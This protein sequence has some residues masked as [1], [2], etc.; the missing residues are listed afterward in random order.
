MDAGAADISSLVLPPEDGEVARALTDLDTKLAAWESA[1]VDAQKELAAHTA[2]I[3]GTRS[4]AERQADT[5]ATAA[6]EQA[7]AS[8]EVE[9]LNPAEPDGGLGD[10]DEAL[11]G[12]LQPE[13][14]Q[15]VRLRYRLFKGRKTVQELV[16]DE[17]EAL[18]NSLEP[19][20]AKAIRVQYRL[21]HGR[22][23]TQEL[24]EQYEA[25]S[26]PKRERKKTWWKKRVKG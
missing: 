7:T 14:A 12:T 19:D 20:A 17:E 10:E 3:A 11:L 9:E 18:L 1:V 21:Y 26:Q 24:V 5:E 23:T 25:E 8:I 2:Q 6:A 13:M 4:A 16:A 22:K 15:V